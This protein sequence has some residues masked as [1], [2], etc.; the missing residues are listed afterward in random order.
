MRVY[1]FG[2]VSGLG[3]VGGPVTTQT[4]MMAK[5]PL[6]FEVVV[7]GGRSGRVSTL[8]PAVNIYT[9]AGQTI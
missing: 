7:L 8:I 4:A 1:G 6:R 3:V 9:K 5:T 2:T